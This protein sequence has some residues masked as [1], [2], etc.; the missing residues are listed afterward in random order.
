MNDYQKA[1]YQKLIE[2]VDLI[3]SMGSY[4][5]ELQVNEEEIYRSEIVLKTNAYESIIP[6]YVRYHDYQNEYSFFL[7]HS[8]PHVRYETEKRIQ[9]EL[10]GKGTQEP[11][12]VHVL[13]KNKITAWVEYLAIVYKKMLEISSERQ[14]TIKAFL[15]EVKKEGGYISEIDPHYHTCSGRIVKNG[16]EFNFE[17]QQ[18]GYISKNIEIHYSVSDNIESFKQLS[19]NKYIQSDKY[20]V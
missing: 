17:V 5:F 3:N 14:K 15:D 18:E 6:V 12:K 4:Q 13:H 8:L 16:V 1:E 11:K 7:R 10:A 20:S 2:A 19:D 9:E